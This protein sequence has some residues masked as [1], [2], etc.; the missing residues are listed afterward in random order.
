MILNNL[1]N[2]YWVWSF[3]GIII[4][5]AIIWVITG[6][7]FSIIVTT[8]TFSAFY[9]LCGIGQMIV[10]TSG[11]GNIDLSI[12]TVISLSGIIA[13]K[14]MN[15]NSSMIIP[16]IVVTLLVGAVLGLCNYSLI[17]FIRIPPIIATMAANFVYQSFA[18]VIS[19]GLFLKPP[20][21]LEKATHVKLLGVPLFVVFSYVIA[22][23]AYLLVEKM[24]WGRKLSAVGQNDWAAKLVKINTSKIRCE[25]YMISAMLAA[26]TGCL[27]AAFSGGASLS[28]GE[29]YML[30]SVAV[31]VIGGTEIAGGKASVLGLVCA[32]ILL[33]LIINLLNILGVSIGIRQIV[34]G[35]IIVSIIVLAKFRKNR[36]TA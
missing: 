35:A 30:I 6:S 34:T 15:E 25:A 36:G 8:L 4:I 22:F 20:E 1:K 28:M 5:T 16:G 33:Y 29:E 24:K 19:Y 27:L 21:L 14:V 9:V 12:P 13:M 11:A 23:L 2:K 31:V 7:I 26:L 17:R 18:I 10:I 3:I 32:A